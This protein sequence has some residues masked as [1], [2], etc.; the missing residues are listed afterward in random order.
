MPLIPLSA[1]LA[2]VAVQA[3]IAQVTV[4][5]DRARVVR[6]GQV[7]LDGKE[8]YELP[9]LDDAVDASTIQL[10]AVG[11]SVL[12]VDVSHIDE[13]DFPRD[14]AR[15]LLAQIEK[16]DD[17]IAL[18]SGARDA[19]ARQL[20][21]MQRITPFVKLDDQGKANPKLNGQGWEPALV[22]LDG[23]IGKLQAALAQ[24]K[25]ALF[26]LQ[27]E[28]ETLVVR[29]GQLGGARRRSGH[30]VLATLSGHG[31]A[32]LTLTYVV[33]SARWYPRYDV[34]FL[35]EAAAAQISFSGE[36]SQESGEDWTDSFLT[37]S[38]AVP[39]T[40]TALPKL[41]SWKIGERERFI[42]TPSP[43]QEAPIPAPPPARPLPAK[44]SSA[45][46]DE[47]RQRLSSLAR[48][49]QE[50][51]E[52]SEEESDGSLQSLA[53]G[54][55]VAGGA[56]VGSPKAGRP[57][58]STAK[59]SRRQ[60]ADMPLAMPPPAPPPA[61]TRERTP[62]PAAKSLA[63]V[64]PQRP[65]VAPSNV[66]QV[67]LAP[68]PAYQPPS[69]SPELPA[70]LAGGYDLSFASLRKETVKTG[71]GPH[72]VPLFSERWPVAAERVVYPAL[73]PEAAFLVAEI[74]NPSERVFPGGQADLSVGA[75]PAGVAQLKLV[76]PG[77]TFTLP[78]GLDR[79]I[80]PIRNVNIVTEEKGVFSKDE[81]THYKVT[82]ELAN[83]YRQQLP[84]R[85]IDQV[86][87]PAN[88]EMQVELEGASPQTSARNKDTGQLEWSLQLP[89]SGKATV[90]YTYSLRRP[91]GYRLYQD[92]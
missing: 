82:I 63:M 80:K 67:G 74:K 3:E 29:A 11:G 31:S 48:A 8:L 62:S 23:S 91:K 69:Y 21:Q 41:L 88:K 13:Q 92:Q 72:R 6:A 84:I 34:Q 22:F 24:A 52:K 45:S 36:V 66:A 28:R 77:E 30:R 46:D 54:H 15:E 42:P 59:R 61:V 81:V 87:L 70:A 71:D 26:V 5:S 14:E 4:Y 83:P 37:L 60:S 51:A 86:P 35:P 64:A 90:T 47:L 38:T 33:G 53:G 43:Q 50:A 75:D 85:V 2:A 55:G 39:S 16:L 68:P 58:S 57:Y 17:R 10:E 56:P 78:L 18:A 9:L 27:R 79:A 40:T 49:P 12:Q 44:E 32:A 89:A 73:A 65:A 20:A 7:Q 19:R 1:L 76:A 25:E